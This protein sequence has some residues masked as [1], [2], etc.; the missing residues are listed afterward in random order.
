MNPLLRG[1]LPE[2]LITLAQLQL[3]AVARRAWAFVRR[4]AGMV[5]VGVALLLFGGTTGVVLLDRSVR[6]SAAFGS[7]DLH[8]LATASFSALVLLGVVGAVGN[9]GLIGF[10]RAEVDLLF[11]APLP[12]RML[13]RYRMLATLANVLAVGPLSVPMTARAAGTLTGV[14][15]T[16]LLLPLLVALVPT[17]WLVGRALVDHRFGTRA[18]SWTA[19]GVGLGI[20]ALAY[21][22]SGATGEAGMVRLRHVIEGPLGDTLLRPMRGL[23]WLLTAPVLPFGETVLVVGGLLLLVFALLHLVERLEETFL[24]LGLEH[25]E[26]FEATVER[27]RR[28]GGAS[29]WAT[30][31]WAIR[32]PRPPWWGGAGPLAWA[33][34]ASLVRMPGMLGAMGG[35]VALGISMGGLVRWTAP[36]GAS[37]FIDGLAAAQAITMNLMI[38]P[39]TLRTDF[40]GEVDRIPMLRALPVRPMAVIAGVVGPTI[41]VLLVAHAVVLFGLV[42][43][44]PAAAA[45]LLGVL[46]LLT[47]ASALVVAVDNAIFLRYP[48]RVSGRGVSDLNMKAVAVQLGG[49]LVGGLLI[50]VGLV[51]GVM[52]AVLGYGVALATVLSASLLA[53]AA[54]VAVWLTSVVW[55]RFDV[56]EDMPP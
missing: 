3:R 40:R 26:R 16:A 39:V 53:L 54:T 37:A 14:V 2:P 19:R 46:A 30:T 50:G 13:V 31:V 43:I 25:G 1:V 5:S 23:G 48:H 17:I 51:P 34:T 33:R 45:Y 32:L 38:L 7:A 24:D 52:L 9:G 6:G 27:A 29:A 10:R 12:R 8:L 28:G 44:R 41:G 21:A 18:G 56:G 47:P 36:G 22:T 11:P 35:T 20:A 49:T 15:L 4:P 42:V 55:R